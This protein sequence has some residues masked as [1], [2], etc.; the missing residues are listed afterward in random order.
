MFRKF[1]GV[2]A[3]FELN[4]ALATALGQGWFRHITYPQEAPGEVW[5]GREI[6][7]NFARGLYPLVDDYIPARLSRD[8]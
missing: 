6:T 7:D 5:Y 3:Y 1:D 4:E 8:P 2:I